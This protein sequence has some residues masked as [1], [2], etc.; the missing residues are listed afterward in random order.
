GKSESALFRGKP[1][2]RRPLGYE[3][4]ISCGKNQDKGKKDNA[5]FFALIFRHGNPSF[6]ILESDHGNRFSRFP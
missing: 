1:E 4:V 3:E 2:D 6:M 5:P